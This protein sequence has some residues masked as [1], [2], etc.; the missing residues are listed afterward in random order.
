MIAFDGTHSKFVWK[1]RDSF[2]YRTKFLHSV[3]RV[4]SLVSMQ[5]AIST[6]EIEF[7]NETWKKI[8]SRFFD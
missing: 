4:V 5:G 1:K 2:E 7:T 8:S 6:C 3:L